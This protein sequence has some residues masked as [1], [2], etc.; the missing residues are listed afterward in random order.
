MA[1][2]RRMNGGRRTYSRLPNTNLLLSGFSFERSHLNSVFRG[3]VVKG[4]VHALGKTILEQLKADI[5]LRMLNMT[6]EVLRIEA[7]IHHIH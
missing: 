7:K 4:P 6:I 1:P 3:S 5:T 2:S